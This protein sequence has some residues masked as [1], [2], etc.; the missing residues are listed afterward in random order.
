ML[1]EK[2]FAESKLAHRVSLHDSVVK[3][4]GLNVARKVMDSFAGDTSVFGNGLDL[5]GGGNA[6]LFKSYGQTYL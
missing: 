5:L 2:L 1:F 6:D 3:L 4:Y